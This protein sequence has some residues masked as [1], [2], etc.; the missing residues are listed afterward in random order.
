[1]ALLNPRLRGNR[2]VN[3]HTHHQ[4]ELRERRGF[5]LLH[6]PSDAWVLFPRTEYQQTFDQR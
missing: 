5:L 1:M 2:A 4:P 6:L 3:Y